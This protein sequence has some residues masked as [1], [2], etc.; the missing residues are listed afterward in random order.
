MDCGLLLNY[1]KIILKNVWGKVG[2]SGEFIV[3]LTPN[4]YKSV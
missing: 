4:I 1:L 2:K 3:T